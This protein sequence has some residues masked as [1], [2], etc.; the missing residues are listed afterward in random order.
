[1]NT[2]SRT[3]TLHYGE[4]LG[5]MKNRNYQGIRELYF[6]KFFIFFFRKKRLYNLTA[7]LQLGILLGPW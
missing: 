7:G 2:G 3:V 5:V 4:G 6:L 1:M